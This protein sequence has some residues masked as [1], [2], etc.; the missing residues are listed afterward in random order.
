MASTMRP[1]PVRI[2]KSLITKLDP[3]KQA[4]R[5]HFDSV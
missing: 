5:N 1:R 4:K 3:F 2:T